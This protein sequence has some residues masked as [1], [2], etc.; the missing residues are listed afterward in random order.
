MMH[1]PERARL[2]TADHPL[3][4]TDASYGNNGAFTLDSCEPGWRLFLICS[5]G[6]EPDAEGDLAH[7]EHV[8]VR[9]ARGQASRIPTWRE[10]CQVKAICWEPDD[11]VVQFHPAHSAY[12]NQHPHVLHLW[13]WKAGAFPTPPVRAV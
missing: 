9:A 13:K 7:W 12:V 5:D 2:T 8:S 4:G 6:T 11:V 10:M 3:M 1:V